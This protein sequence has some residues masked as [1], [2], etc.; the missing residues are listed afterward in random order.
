MNSRN[1]FDS[2]DK[3]RKLKET[4]TCSSVG[5]KM[6]IQNFALRNKGRQVPY[7]EEFFADLT[8]I[9]MR[10]IIQRQTIG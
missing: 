9:S 3:I 8:T 5:M 10:Q 4:K 1:M 7:C 6:S 2:V